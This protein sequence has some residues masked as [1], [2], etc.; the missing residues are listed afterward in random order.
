MAARK[1]GRQPG[2]LMTDAHRAKLQNSG[3]LNALVEHVVGEREMSATQVT[4]GI[5]LLKKIMPD[6]ASVEHSGEIA[7]GD[8]DRL[9]DA[10]LA[11]IAARG[12]GRAL[13]TEAEIDP[14]Q[15]N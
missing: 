8:L 15:L 11:A 10:Q 9:T 13:N 12:E 5:A 14:S 4:A 7:V 6:L 2:F 3:I 1:P